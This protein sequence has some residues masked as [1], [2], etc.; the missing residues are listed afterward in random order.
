MAKKTGKHIKEDIIKLFKHKWEYL[1]KRPGYKEDQQ[2]FDELSGKEALLYSKRS[3]LNSTE[4]AKYYK[5]TNA[6]KALLKKYNVKDMPDPNDDNGWEVLR[7]D[8]YAVIPLNRIICDFELLNSNYKDFKIDIWRK[9]ETV[10]QEVSDWIDELQE[11]EKHKL[12]EVEKFDKSP[13]LRNSSKYLRVFELRNKKPPT[14]YRTIVV[15]LMKEGYYSNTSIIKKIDRAES[16]VK[17]DYAVAFKEV[18]GIPYKE[19]NMNELRKSDFK[20][21]E[22]CAKYN[23]C[24][25]PCSEAE[26]A[27]SLV[28]VN[29][30][31]RLLT[32]EL[33]IMK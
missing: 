25:E 4:K 28:E 24:K 13:H 1:R 33:A 23:S 7:F 18:F 8:N 27:I 10:I 17:K 21:C 32:K 20:T 12:K 22:G 9:K 14:P 5:I 6:Q 16:L 3:C 29:Q 19:H 30:E 2:A 31:E 26:Y 11:E 15:T